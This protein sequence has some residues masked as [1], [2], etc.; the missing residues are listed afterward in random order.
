[1]D[2]FTQRLTDLNPDNIL[3][4]GYSITVKAGTNEVVK[5]Q[6]QVGLDEKL[7]I[8]LHKGELEVR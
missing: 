1:M 7:T 8:K 6:D 5:D 2:S 4:R 3:K